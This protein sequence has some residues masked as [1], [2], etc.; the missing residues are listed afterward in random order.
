MNIKIRNFTCICVV[1]FSFLLLSIASAQGDLLYRV[2]DLGT[3]PGPASSSKANAIN[4]SGVIAG[5]TMAQYGYYRAFRYDTSMH[6]LGVLGTYDSYSYAYGIN[7]GGKVV[8]ISQYNNNGSFYA[9]IQD[10][11]TMSHIP[12][13]PYN[14]P[15]YAYSINDNGLIVGFAFVS[16]D[17]YHAYVYDS[18]TGGSPQDLGTLGG[19]LSQARGIN[20]SG[21]I[22]G[23]ANYDMNSL[24]KVHA[25]L[26]TAS[27]GLIDL[28]TLGGNI[29]YAY[30]INNNRQI[31]GGSFLSATGSV[32]HALRAFVDESGPHLTDLGVLPG[33]SSSMGLGINDSG[34]TVGFSSFTGNSHAFLHDGVIMYDLNTLLDSSGAGWEILEAQDIN[35]NGR[36]V[37]QGVFNGN[38]HAVLLTPVPEPATWVLLAAGLC[39]LVFVSRR[40]R[41]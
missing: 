2:T 25:F 9:F 13:L 14:G 24:S 6:D 3:L 32:T 19:H 26:K 18:I 40:K 35:N 4:S 41:R 38:W 31:V 22:I 21:D 11:A 10:G 29:S 27:S 37:G 8:G 30:G 15:N 39:F 17:Y 16:S 34:M 7:S 12:S 5:E 36:I 33:S 1:V 23:W 28:G 20:N